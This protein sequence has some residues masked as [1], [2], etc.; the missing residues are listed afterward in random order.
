MNSSSRTRPLW[1]ATLLSLSLVISACASSGRATSASK[2]GSASPAGA[3]ANKAQAAPTTL[4]GIYYSATSILTFKAGTW[5]RNVPAMDGRFTVSANRLLLSSEGCSGQGTYTWA[6]TGEVLTLTK[7]RDS[8]Q[9]RD[10]LFASL[11]KWGVVH[12]WGENLENGDGL[13]LADNQH[14]ANFHGQLDVTGRSKAAIEVSL[15]ITSGLIFSPT[16]LIGTPGQSVALTISNPAKKTTENIQHNFKLDELGVLAEV[17][18]G[19]STT[20]TVTFPKSGGLR[21]YCA[22]HARFNQQ[23]ELL[24]SP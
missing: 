5:T 21:F 18:F 4:D 16:V 14:V 19:Q 10:V 7:V 20:V 12:Q 1:M 2:A 8:C 24:V 17:P 15:T 9:S 6:L 23:G 13:L 11:E 22:Y 3:S